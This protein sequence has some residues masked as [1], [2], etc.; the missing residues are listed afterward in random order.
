M[1]N[2]NQNLEEGLSRKLAQVA[3][4]TAIATSPINQDAPTPDLDTLYRNHP[5]KVNAA[6]RILHLAKVAM[7]LKKV[8]NKL[9]KEKAVEYATLAVK[10]EHPVFP[11][12]E[13]LMALMAV[14]STFN[15]K[16]ISGKGAFGLTQIIPK[17]HNTTAKNLLSSP[18]HAVSLGAKILKDN[19][20]KSD[21]NI[22]LAIE[23]YNTGIYG[24]KFQ[25]K[26]AKDYVANN[27]EFAKKF[28]STSEPDMEEK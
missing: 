13:D 17:W 12:A 26:R 19:Y 9:P 21:G 23:Y 24:Y 14:E 3:T 15:E 6:K 2:N 16:A 10:H 27:T 11:K 25:G 5:V 18:E 22:P 20:K 8:N 1:E 4:A 7:S 28:R